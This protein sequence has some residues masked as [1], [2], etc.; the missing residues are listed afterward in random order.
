[1]LVTSLQYIYIYNKS[2][3]S[4]FKF[5]IV[6]FYPSIKKLIDAI[7]WARSYINISVQEVDIIMHC[8]KMFIF[9]EDECWVKKNDLSSDVSTG[10]LDSAEVCELV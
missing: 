3:Y 10:S 8:K 6:S 2:N 5:D 1:M 9:L 4:F 7:Q